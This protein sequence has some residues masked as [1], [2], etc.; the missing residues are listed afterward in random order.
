MRYQCFAT[1]GNSEPLTCQDTH[2]PAHKVKQRRWYENALALGVL[3]KQASWVQSCTRRQQLLVRIG[4]QLGNASAAACSEHYASLISFVLQLE[5]VG[6]V[7]IAGRSSLGD[8]V[9]RGRES[10]RDELLTLLLQQCVDGLGKLGMLRRVDEMLAVELG[11]HG[12]DGIRGST[13]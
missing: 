8:G 6:K 3:V 5:V 9:G 12:N 10:K 11:Q 2:R 4:A 7:A 1:Q 13:R